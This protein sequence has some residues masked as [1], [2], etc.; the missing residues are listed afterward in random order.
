MK[1]GPRRVPGRVLLRERERFRG[2]RKYYPNYGQVGGGGVDG[3]RPLRQYVFSPGKYFIEEESSLAVLSRSPFY[4]TELLRSP[5]SFL[6]P[7][8]L[9]ELKILEVKLNIRVIRV[10]IRRKGK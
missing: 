9:Y 8:I 2:E 7:T 10:T 1:C 6:L 4:P 5:Q 3:R